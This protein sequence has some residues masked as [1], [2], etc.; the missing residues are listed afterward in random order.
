MR[1]STLEPSQIV[2]PLPT[3]DSIGATNITVSLNDVHYTDT[4]VMMEFLCD[5]GKYSTGS[6][7]FVDGGPFTAEQPLAR[8]RQSY[9]RTP[10]PDGRVTVQPQCIDCQV[11]YYADRLGQSG[12]NCIGHNYTGHN[13]IGATPTASARAAITV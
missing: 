2:C 11:G 13:H 3:V 4:K 6:K 10:S 8:R 7:I 12:H 9:I 5:Y 1:A